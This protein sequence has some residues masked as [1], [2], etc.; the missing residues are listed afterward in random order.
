MFIIPTTD[1]GRQNLNIFFLISSLAILFESKYILKIKLNI[2]GYFFF[3]D[4]IKAVTTYN[5]VW[6]LIKHFS[7]PALENK[8]NPVKT[9]R[10]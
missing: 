1:C 6:C 7:V 10:S 5:V 9:L 4:L 8:K 3:S 2:Y